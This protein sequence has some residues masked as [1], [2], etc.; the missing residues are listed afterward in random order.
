MRDGEN[1]F[2]RIAER[3]LNKIDICRD[4]KLVLVIDI[5]RRADQRHENEGP[6]GPFDASVEWRSESAPE[7]DFQ[8][9][10]D[11]PAPRLWYRG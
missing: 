3:H 4:L 5:A 11:R 10:T 1:P 8:R 6:G 7:W 9:S 2:N